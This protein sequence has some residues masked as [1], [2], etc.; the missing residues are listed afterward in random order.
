MSRQRE[1]QK[2]MRFEGKCIICGKEAAESL[3]KGN[4]NHKSPY[5]PEHLVI[6]RERNRSSGKRSRR[7]WNARSYKEALDETE[8]GDPFDGGGNSESP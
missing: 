3:R 5:C 2:Q 8:T 1:Y 4:P 7:N 6:V